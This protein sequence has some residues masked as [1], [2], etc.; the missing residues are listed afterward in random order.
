LSKQN[1]EIIA[2]G[3]LGATFVMQAQIGNKSRAIFVVGSVSGLI[4]LASMA[5]TNT[6]WY[7]TISYA[8]SKLCTEMTTRY[9]GPQSLCQGHAIQWHGLAVFR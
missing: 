4:P 7:M 6:R 3:S 1:K 2:G 9:R 8:T 5:P